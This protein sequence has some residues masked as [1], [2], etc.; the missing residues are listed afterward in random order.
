MTTQRV[1]IELPESI[2]HRFAQIAEATQQPLEKL[3]AQ[4]VVSNL[5]PFPENLPLELHAEFMEM[6]TLGVDEL[7]AIAQTQADATQH[8]RHEQLLDR[9]QAGLLTPEE[10]TELTSLRLIADQLMLRKSYAWAILRWKG[11]RIPPLKELVV[12][13]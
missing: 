3:V 6:Q 11:H 13:L 5:P 1:T 7:L 4:S 12:P 2:L 10:Q 8:R 9:N